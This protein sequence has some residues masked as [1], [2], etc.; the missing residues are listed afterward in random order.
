M[1]RPSGSNANFQWCG[2]NFSQLP[3][4]IGFGGQVDYFG[5]HLDG[6][7]DAGMSRASATYARCVSRI[8][9]AFWT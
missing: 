2:V 4:G 7:L 1:H 3:N 6:T 8:L 9:E 5:M